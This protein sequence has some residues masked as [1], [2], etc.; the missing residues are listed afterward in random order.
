LQPLHEDGT[1]SLRFRIICGGVHMHA[2]ALDPLGLL[3]TRRERPGDRCSA[4]N[5]NKLPP[6]HVPSQNTSYGVPEA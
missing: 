4:E 1:V 6:T 5:G 3:R 2:D